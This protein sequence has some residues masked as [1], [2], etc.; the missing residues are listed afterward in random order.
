LG[1]LGV[2]LVEGIGRFVR[3][4]EVSLQDTNVPTED[5]ALR[6]PFATLLLLLLLLWLLL[7]LLRG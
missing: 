2:V 1:E 7:L 4:L 3:V 6:T 5:A